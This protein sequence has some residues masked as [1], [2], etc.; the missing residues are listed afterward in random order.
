[1]EPQMQVAGGPAAVLMIAGVSVAA[2]A[3]V[4]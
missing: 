3:A 2:M 4:K 1:M